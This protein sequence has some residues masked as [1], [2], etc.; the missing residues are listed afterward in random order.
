[1]I[2]ECRVRDHAR[3]AVCIRLPVTDN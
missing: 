2:F 1:M 3:D